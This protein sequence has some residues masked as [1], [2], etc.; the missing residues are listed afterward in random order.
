[1]EPFTALS[2]ASAIVQFVD[3]SSKILKTGCEVYRSSSGL[4]QE[5]VDLTEL[6]TSLYS[7]QTRLAASTATQNPD[8][9]AL[10]DLVT[11]CTEISKQLLEVLRDLQVEGDGLI[12]T[13]E[14]LRQTIRSVG[15][16]KEISR[17]ERLLDEIGRQI[18]SRLLYSIR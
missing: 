9:R 8:E 16:K 14:S 6:T 2:L 11:K 13:W 10:Q 3:F 5:H 7:F 4:A 12:R 1:M 18:S 17:L 15:K